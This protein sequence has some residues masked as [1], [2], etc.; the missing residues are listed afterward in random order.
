M[1]EGRTVGEFPSGV[2]KSGRGGMKG[3]AGSESMMDESWSFFPRVQLLSHGLETKKKSGDE[4]TH[5]E[6]TVGTRALFSILCGRDRELLF[7]KGR[8]IRSNKEKQHAGISSNALWVA[9]TPSM[10]R[11]GG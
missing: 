5:E 2:P 3:V 4:R 9:G 8:K 1:T 11:R 7:S 10:K 6:K